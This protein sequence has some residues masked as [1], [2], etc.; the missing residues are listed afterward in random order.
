ARP[1]RKRPGARPSP[2][3]ATFEVPLFRNNPNAVG[4]LGIAATRDGRAPGAHEESSRLASKL[5][6]CSAEQPSRNQSGLTVDFMDFTDK[7]ERNP[8]HPESAVKIRSRVHFFC[9][10][11]FAFL[12]RLSPD[13]RPNRSGKKMEAKISAAKSRW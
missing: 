9:L 7:R 10:H 2:V 12:F 11:F 3:A 1:S 4:S 5:D 6:D 8:R 13:L